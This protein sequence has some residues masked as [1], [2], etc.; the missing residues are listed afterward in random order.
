MGHDQLSW[1]FLNDVR[2]GPKIT[3]SCLYNTSYI[4][5]GCLL[6]RYDRVTLLFLSDVYLGLYTSSHYRDYN[7]NDVRYYYTSI[8][9]IVTDF[10]SM[11]DFPY[12]NTKFNYCKFDV[13]VFF[14][15][16]IDLK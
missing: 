12:G 2:L 10:D 1:L 15:L 3:V 7:A 14:Y 11:P 4:F 9:A 5:I 13:W 8:R 6:I 16:L